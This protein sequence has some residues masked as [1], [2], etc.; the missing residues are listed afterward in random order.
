MRKVVVMIMAMS[1]L[2]AV[3]AAAQPVHR[4]TVKV[5]IDCESVDSLGGEANVRKQIT[6]MFD[7]VNRAFNHSRRFNAV[8]DFVVDWDA[9][10]IYL[11]LLVFFG[12]YFFV[13]SFFLF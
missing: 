7:K 10:Y 1:L 6:R 4:F 12:V 3:S 13:F 11:F 2:M 8:Y 9:F 5:G